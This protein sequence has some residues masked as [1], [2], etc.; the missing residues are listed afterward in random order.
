LLGSGVVGD[1]STGGKI[2][3]ASGI[4]VD[5]SGEV[6]V[7]GSGEVV[8]SGR[9]EIGVSVGGSCTEGAEANGDAVAKKGA[10]QCNQRSGNGIGWV[11]VDRRKMS[12]CGLFAKKRDEGR[13][14]KCKRA[15][16][17]CERSSDA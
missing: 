14:D 3:V 12:D 2:G 16:L 10:P 5:D 6:G 1:C 9:G 8:V 4:D 7:R 17:T 15:N 13:S 11:A